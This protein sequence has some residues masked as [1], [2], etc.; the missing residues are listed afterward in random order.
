MGK[1]YFFICLCT[2]STLSSEEIIVPYSIEVDQQ[3]NLVIANFRGV[4]DS[5]EFEEELTTM[6]D[7]GPYDGHYRLQHEFAE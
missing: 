7:M 3:K 5:N 4:F 6:D 1:K 2:M